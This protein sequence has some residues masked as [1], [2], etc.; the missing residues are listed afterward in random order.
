MSSN[1]RC[2]GTTPREPWAFGEQAVSI[3]RKYAQLRYRLL[4]YLYTYAEIAAR[5]GLPA[6]RPLVLEYQDDP[7][8]HRLDTEYLVGEDLLVAPV[9]EAETTRSVYLPDGEWTHYWDGTRYDGGQTVEIDAP[10][11]TMPIFQKAGSILPTQPPAQHVQSGTPETLTFWCC[12]DGNSASGRYYDE[13][14][15]ALVP[16][17]AEIRDSSIQINVPDLATDRV[18]IEIEADE[19]IEVSDVIVNSE[20]VRRVDDDPGPGEWTESAGSILVVV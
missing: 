8:T 18:D 16:I 20:T 15:D 5:T 12:F 19:P 6:V 3:F 10:L 1:S 9:F 4:P 7:R 2:H 17:T 11:D 13:D 14:A